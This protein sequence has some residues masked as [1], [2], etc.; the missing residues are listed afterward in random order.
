MSAGSEG[1]AGTAK[2]EAQKATAAANEA[3]AA[4]SRAASNKAFNQRGG[5][6]ADKE[7]DTG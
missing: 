3:R 7:L 6:K 4:A 5:G 1:A 2:G